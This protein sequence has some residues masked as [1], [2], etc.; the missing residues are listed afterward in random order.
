MDKET[1]SFLSTSVKLKEFKKEQLEKHQ[2]LINQELTDPCNIWIVCEKSKMSNAEQ[3]LASLTDERSI[4]SSIF[5]PIDTMKVRF[6]RVHRWDKIKE[7]E[8]NYK[9]EG[10]VVSKED[11]AN[12]LEVKGT[13]KGR[14][15]MIMFLERLAENV[16]CKVYM[17]TYVLYSDCLIHLLGVPC[18]K[19]YFF[20]GIYAVS[21]VITGKIFL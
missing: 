12:S 19:H 5:K 1:A 10:V 2:V 9:D 15:D 3:E 13:K 8:R 16:D 14:V 4:G 21:D 17:R 11:A 20:K 7:K 6:L 18:K